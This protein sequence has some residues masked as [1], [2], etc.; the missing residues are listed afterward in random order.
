MILTHRVGIKLYDE[1]GNLFKDNLSNSNPILK[2][3]VKNTSQ[4]G[5]RGPNLDQESQNNKFKC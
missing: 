3:V 5:S 4:T 1:V 2:F